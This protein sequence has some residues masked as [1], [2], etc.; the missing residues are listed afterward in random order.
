MRNPFRR[1][2]RL[3]YTL[4]FSQSAGLPASLWFDCETC[5]TTSLLRTLSESQD[6][7]TTMG[8]CLPLVLAHV[9]IHISEIGAVK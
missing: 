1:R 9:S 2:K 7:V 6:V 4:A 8:E 3:G 5:R